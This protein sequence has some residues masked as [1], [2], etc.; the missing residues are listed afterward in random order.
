MKTLPVFLNCNLEFSQSKLATF[1]VGTVTNGLSSN[2]RQVSHPY[3]V[4]LF[5][6]MGCMKTYRP[7]EG[8]FQFHFAVSNRPIQ[9]FTYSKFRF[10][11][12]KCFTTVYET[13]GRCTNSRWFNSPR[14]GNLSFSGNLLHSGSISFEGGCDPDI[15]I[16]STLICRKRTSLI[17]SINYLPIY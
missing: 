14:Y 9:F 16:L 17:L 10:F 4:S 8:I 7:R 15:R 2:R 1:I 13:G 5:F 11:A 12:H 6:R 3:H